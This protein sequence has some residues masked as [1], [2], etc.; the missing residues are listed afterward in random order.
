MKDDIATSSRACAGPTPLTY[1]Y[2]LD[3]T[4]YSVTSKTFIGS[5]FALVGLVEHRGRAD[6]DGTRLPAALRRAI[7]K[8]NPDLIFLA[9]TKCCPRT[10]TTVKARPGWSTMTAV[11]SRRVVRSTTTSRPAGARAS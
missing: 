1:Y 10:A 9:D 5:L 4:F 7:V 3:P 6:A 2:E 11:S 8:A